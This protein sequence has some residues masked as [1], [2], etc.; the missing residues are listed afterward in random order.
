MLDF[1]GVIVDSVGIKDLAFREL[2]KAFP[3]HLS[4]IMEYHLAHN[5]TIRYDK[6]RFISQEILGTPYTLAEQQRLSSQF[7]EFVVKRILSCPFVLGAIDF[8]NYFD[9]RLPIY[10]ISMSPDDELQQ[11]LTKRNLLH[12]FSG[13]YASNWNKKKDAIQHILELEDIDHTEAVFI[14]DSYEDFQASELAQVHFIGRNSGKSFKK[15]NI[16]IG[17]DMYDVRKMFS[18]I[19]QKVLCQIK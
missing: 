6:F 11:I 14:G 12:Y 10:L 16:D 8:L 7:S 5:A 9:H 3:D 13:V 4:A 19:D 18:I 1:D 15:A 2:Y 17:E